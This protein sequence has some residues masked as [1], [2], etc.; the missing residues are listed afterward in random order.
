MSHKSRLERKK[1]S[2]LQ[3]CYAK[4]GKE[5]GSDSAMQRRVWRWRMYSWESEQSGGV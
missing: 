2:K 4:V 1:K 3:G 5:V